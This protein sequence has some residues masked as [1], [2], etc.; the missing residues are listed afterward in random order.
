MFNTEIL[1]ALVSS[2]GCHKQRA[3]AQFNRAS[4]VA[5]GLLGWVDPI[6]LNNEHYRYVEVEACLNTDRVRGTVDDF[7]VYNPDDEPV[8]DVF[9][10]ELNAQAQTKVL[11]EYPISRQMNIMRNLLMAMAAKLDMTHENSPEL[12]ELR[13]MSG[14]IDEILD[15]NAS[16]KEHFA[17]SPDYNYISVED[18]EAEYEATLDGGLHEVYGSR[19]TSL[20]QGV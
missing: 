1:D 14:Y 16:R 15:N 13:E 20:I 3:L 10:T 17:A 9:E 11:K 7:T 12:N 6:T 19:T 18:N 8:K 5:L 2:S 4:G